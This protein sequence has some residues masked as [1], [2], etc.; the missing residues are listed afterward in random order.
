MPYDP[1]L[2]W[3]EV[4]LKECHL[5]RA[6]NCEKW[7]SWRGVNKLRFIP[8]KAY[9]AAIQNHVEEYAVTWKNVRVLWGGETIA[10]L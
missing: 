6:F 5:Y 2:P 8:M 4:H 9:L 3:P 10:P 1:E 7:G